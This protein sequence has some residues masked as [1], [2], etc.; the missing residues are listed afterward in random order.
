[1]KKIL[2]ALTLLF[3]AHN[4]NAQQD[5]QFTHYM[6][7]NLSFNPGYAGITQSIC[8]TVL[9]RQ[10][11]AGFDGSPTTALINVHA[12]VQALRGGIG[13]SYLNDQLGFEKNNIARLSYSYHMSVG[14][15]ELG[16]GLSAGI[17]QK[18]FDATWITPDQGTAF[19]PADDNSIPINNASGVVPDFNLGLFYKT[20]QLFLG[21]STTH[22]GGFEMDDLN[23]KNVHHYWITGG[24][25]YDINPDWRLRPSLLIKSDAASTIMDLNVNVLYKSMIWAGATYRLGDAI[26]PMMGYQHS[27]DDGATLR[28]GYSYGITTSD[29]GNYNNGTHDIMLNYCFNLDKPPVLQKSKNPRFL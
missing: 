5:Y 25:N 23:V 15:G 14:V 9:F 20:N 7:D 17:I 13:L 16:I 26:A 22:L 28:I 4:I 18:S 1:M 11:W 12:P 19:V 10:Q 24:Y 8:G 21:V 2:I 3:G 27:F 29:L 6:F